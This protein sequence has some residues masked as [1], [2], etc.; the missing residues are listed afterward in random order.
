MLERPVILCEI[1]LSLMLCAVAA[2]TE[3]SLLKTTRF[4]EFSKHWFDMLKS[5][6]CY[7]KEHPCFIKDPSD[8]KSVIAE[9]REIKR[10]MEKRVKKTASETVPYVGVLKYYVITYRARGDS[11]EAASKG[12][13]KI[14][15][16]SITTEIFYY[17]N[18]AWVY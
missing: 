13:F 18:G 14:T 10:I 6:G 8:P 12:K 3:D 4:D 9:Y 7:S 15:D 1:L 16:Q 2:H 5:K 11:K 17:K